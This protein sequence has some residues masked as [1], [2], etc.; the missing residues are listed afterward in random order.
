[1]A[2]AMR[3]SIVVPV[4]DEAGGIASTLAALAPLRAAGHEVIVADGGSRDET[5]ALAAPGADLVIVADRGRASQMNAGA[6]RASGDVLVFLH[7]DTRLPDDAVDAIADAIRG[8]ARWGRFDV[9]IDGRSRW[10]PVVAAAMNL[11]SRLTG[12]ATGDQGM[13]VERALFS[14]VGGFPPIALMED[15]ALSRT[16]KRAAGRPACVSSRVHTSGRRWDRDGA[17]STI[18]L[19][20]RLRAAWALGV[21]PSSLARR[22]G[23]RR[24]R[25]RVLQVFAKAPVPGTVKTRLASALGERAATEA[26]VTLAEHALDV[27]AEA[28][29]RG[30]VAAIELWCAPDA[31]HPTLVAW[32]R[33]CGATL[34]EQR[35][36]DLGARMRDA[37][38][39]ALARDALPILIGTDCPA[40]DVGYLDAASRALDTDAIVLGPVEDGGYALVG[41]SR[42]V[43]AFDAIP[44]ST[45]AVMAQTRA[46]LARAGARWRE[47]PLLWDVD[48]A[49]DLARWRAP[50]ADAA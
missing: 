22:Y 37:L 34:H 24:V 41:A 47:L 38:H 27:A 29:R 21:D 33:R 17:L 5:V 15:L 18:V 23:R 14:R 45:P 7:A 9:A 25:P 50:R 1:M 40:I 4:L 42:D 46:A 3:L 28:R 26:Y 32:A 31:S 48:T 19:M 49:D 12:I 6:A 36:T 20:W 8:G 44:W 11:R 16:L 13:F 30:V 43:D 39:D 10:L 35:G 2:A